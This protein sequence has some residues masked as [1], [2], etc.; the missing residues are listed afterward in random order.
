MPLVLTFSSVDTQAGEATLAS[1]SEWQMA[2]TKQWAFIPGHQL[3]PQPPTS[4]HELINESQSHSEC[5]L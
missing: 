3:C 4:P 2:N 5:D 1:Q